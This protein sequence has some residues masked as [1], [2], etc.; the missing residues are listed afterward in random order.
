MSWIKKHPLLSV[1][2]LAMAVRLLSLGAYPL[3]DT[4]EARYGYMAKLMVM[5][6]N[7]LTPQF[8][9]G[10]PFWGKP[11]L[12]TWMSAGSASLL[13]MSEFALRLP[14]WLAAAMIVALVGWIARRER[15]SAALAMMTLATTVIF[16]IAAGAIMTDMALTLG[17]TIA[18]IGFYLGWQGNYRAGYLGFVGL[19]IGLLA[20]GPLII[21]LMGLAVGPWLLIQ[22]GLGAF[23]VL[24]QR[25]PL[26]TGTAAMFVI[27]GPWY[28]AAEKATPGFLDYFI[29]GEH[30]LRFVE[31][32]WQGDLYG[33]AHDQ[34]RGTIWIYWLSSA[35]PWSLILPLLWWRQRK[36]DKPASGVSAW[37][38]YLLCWMLSP[39][40]LFTFAGNILPA[41]IL[42][43]IPALALLC[44]SLAA[45]RDWGWL[46]KVGMIT[47]VILLIA[48][49]VMN[50][51]VGPE[52]SDKSL[53]A[54]HYQPQTPLYYL[55]KRPFSA[56]Y[57]SDGRAQFAESIDE[58]PTVQRY[59]LAI[60]SDW[61]WQQLGLENQQCTVLEQR[62]K[63]QLLECQPD[64]NLD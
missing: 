49:A 1:M 10:V 24:W 41:Y 7:W 28:L 2:L 9:I 58:L 64:A 35:F 15:S 43:G 48:V 29:V 54:G 44:A 21:V 46:T 38:S 14:H 63:R 5:T 32:G 23:K 45:Q 56:Q 20:K 30:Y 40:I 62:R 13:G 4:T 25:F 37:Q 16:S 19:A 59:L 51:K 34:P 27:A 47:P 39:L 3:T 22:H 17:M 26:L 12:H 31:S 33:S 6:D 18:M 53:L 11:P 61:N 60:P 52:R 50:V 57:Y 36:A 55:H 42:P 8:D